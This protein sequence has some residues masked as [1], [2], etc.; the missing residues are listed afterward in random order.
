MTLMPDEGT[1]TVGNLETDGHVHT[2][3]V[4][5]HVLDQD[6][7]LIDAEPSLIPGDYP[8]STDS[9]TSVGA[10]AP[11]SHSVWA[12]TEVDKLLVCVAADG[13]SFAHTHT[14]ITKVS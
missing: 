14:T 4:G 3:I 6:V 2:F 8:R 13:P 5:T 7:D 9:A 1:Y 12:S 11:H 10:R